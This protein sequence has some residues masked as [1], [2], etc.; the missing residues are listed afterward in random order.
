MG[1]QLGP[2]AIADTATTSPTPT[3]LKGAGSSREWEAQLLKAPALSLVFEPRTSVHWRSNGHSSFQN[4]VQARQE[5]RADVRT[6]RDHHAGDLRRRRRSRT[7]GVTSGGGQGHGD[8]AGVARG[9]A[10]ANDLRRLAR[11]DP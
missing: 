7:T 9:A 2:E 4:P 11:P 3:S 5:R 10:R 8:A 6:R 1:R